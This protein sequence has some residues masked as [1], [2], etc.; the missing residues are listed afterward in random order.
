M[1][2]I[3]ESLIILRI[4]TIDRLFLIV[5]VKVLPIKV[6]FKSIIVLERLLPLI[7]RELRVT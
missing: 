6:P 4:W 2:L 5:I 3:N 1:P 7:E